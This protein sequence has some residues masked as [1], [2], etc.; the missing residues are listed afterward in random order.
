M[1]LTTSSSAGKR[2]LLLKERLAKN[3]A[4]LGGHRI[5]ARGVTGLVVGEEIRPCQKV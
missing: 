2:C 3:P 5:T 1:P 4:P